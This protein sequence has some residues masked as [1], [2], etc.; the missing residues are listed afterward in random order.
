MDQST[1]VEMQIE[2]GRRLLERLVGEGIPV[3]AAAWLKESE[4][5]QWFL[6]VVTPLVGEDGATRPAYRRVNA[7]VRHMQP[8]FGINPLEIK[9]VGP[10]SPVGEALRDLPGRYPGP[11][12]LRYGGAHLGGLSIDG[13]YVYPLIVASVR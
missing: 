6:Y 11:S 5:G 13:A 2:D 12:L 3:T 9:L 7:V 8:P 1:L 4:T 10:G